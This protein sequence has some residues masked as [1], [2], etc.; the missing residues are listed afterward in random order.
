M[1]LFYVPCPDKASAESIAK[2]L[3]QEKRVGCANI[4]ANMESHYWWQG[5]LDQS[6]EYVLILKT[7]Q[8]PGI[9]ETL[10]KRIEE[11]HPYDIPCVMI[12]PVLGINESYK[13]WLEESMK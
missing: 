3:L 10:S 13:N 2:T 4:I 1:L 6:S 8:N 7:L 12:L 11:L 9:Q 5:Q